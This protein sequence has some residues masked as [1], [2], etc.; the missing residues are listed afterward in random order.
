M[1]G[2]LNFIN[3]PAPVWSVVLALLI[4]IMAGFH[5]EKK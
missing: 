5:G 1:Q 3:Q 4:G 2:V